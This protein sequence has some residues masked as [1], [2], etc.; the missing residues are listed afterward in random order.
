[1]M[2]GQ[3]SALAIT[4]AYVLAGELA[5]AAGRHHEAFHNYESLLRG[6]I[7]S[8]QSGAERFSSAFAPRTRWGVFL[9]NQVIKACAIPGVPRLV[10]G[11]DIIDKLQLPD[12]RWP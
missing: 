10:F 11:K 8:K 12:Y 1:L 6:Y 7:S 5:K 2:G 9:R 3:G 4:G